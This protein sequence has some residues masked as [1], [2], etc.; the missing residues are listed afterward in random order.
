M[1]RGEQNLLASTSLR[2]NFNETKEDNIDRLGRNPQGADM[3]ARGSLK[4]IN[5]I[6]Y[7]WLDNWKVI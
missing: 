1:T 3:I 2:R 7:F 6:V 5:F 4:I